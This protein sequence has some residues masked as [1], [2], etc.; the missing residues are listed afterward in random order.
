MCHFVSISTVIDVVVTDVLSVIMLVKLLVILL[1]ISTSKHWICT[2]HCW[3][4]RYIKTNQ[5]TTLQ[6]GLLYEEMR[7]REREREIVRK[8][9]LTVTPLRKML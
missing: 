3:I 4:I 5:S 6:Y 8:E 1:Y 2:H 9:Q 7:K